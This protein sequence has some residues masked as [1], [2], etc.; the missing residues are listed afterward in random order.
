MR[1]QSN[2]VGVALLLGVT[3]VALGTLTA[4]VGVVVERNAANADAARV[5]ADFEGALEPIE[6]TGRNRDRVSFTGGTLRTVEREL[7]VLDE[8]GVVHTAQVDALTFTA[9]RHRVAFLSGA[10]VSG[11]EG[12]SRL[13][14]PPPITA[15][16][17]GED[18]VL[19]VG[20]AVLNAS[21]VAVS[22]TASDGVV[23]RT[24][25]TH[26]RVALGNDTYRVAVETR[27]PQVWS[28][29]FQRQGAT[30]ETQSRDFDGDGV[31][32][33]VVRF[34][35]VRAGYVVVHDMHLEVDRG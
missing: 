22:G 33:V 31:E 26:E 24:T 28:E 23:L 18:G 19:V 7:R 17:D 4:S 12:Q 9:G 34:P 10:V 25:V 2:V 1:G 13:H 15:S 29:F 27:D 11:R 30:V 3:V 35:G 16:E 14:R 5:A 6:T 8:S 21:Q 32:S 20:A